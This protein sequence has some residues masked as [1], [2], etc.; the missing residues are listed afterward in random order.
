M[1]VVDEFRRRGFAITEGQLIRAVRAGLARVSTPGSAALPAADAALLDASGLPED[2]AAPT[3]AE[4]AVSAAAHLIA[5]SHSPADAAA[6]LGISPSRL[7][8][9]I[10]DGDVYQV[11]LGRDRYLPR[12]QFRDNKPL[13]GLAAVLAALP[14][15]LHPLAVEGFMTTPDPD[16]DGMS[17]VAWLT[18]GGDPHAVA[19]QAVGLDRW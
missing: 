17:A 11:Q 3:A 10:A 19:A 7:S 18:A 8:H 4:A 2:P 5:E 6:L 1:T 14:D 12:W 15:E 9:R 13:P 16:L